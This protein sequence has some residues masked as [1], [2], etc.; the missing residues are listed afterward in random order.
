MRLAIALT[1]ALAL[2]APAQAA[3]IAVDL[4]APGDH[5]VAR[6]TVTGLDWLRL[7]APAP[8]PELGFRMAT[9]AE[10]LALIGAHAPDVPG[11]TQLMQLTGSSIHGIGDSRSDFGADG[12]VV[13]GIAGVG[14]ST[15]CGT[16]GP[17]V[18]TYWSGYW[19][20]VWPHVGTTWRVREV[21]EPGTA[22][23][24]VVGLVAG[25]TARRRAG[26]GA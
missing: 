15:E 8:A 2:P 23:L 5:L 10:V 20:G 22:A 18:T 3:L 24:V 6:D 14:Y 19:P 26:R 21:P 7:D 4:A 12:H 9:P 11:A 1:L 25:A 13:G 17:C 16:P